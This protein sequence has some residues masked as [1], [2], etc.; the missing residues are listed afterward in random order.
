MATFLDVGILEH[1]SVIFIFLL[2]FAITYAVLTFSNPFGKEAKG[3]YAIIALAISFLVVRYKPAILMINFMTPWFLVAF[4]FI[5]FMLV[6]IGMFGGGQLNLIKLVS[7]PQVYIWIIIISVI[8][9]VFG[10]SHTMGQTLLER[11]PGN[12]TVSG[13]IEAGGSTQT[14][15]FSQ[16]VVNTLFHPKILGTLLI[17]MVGLFTIIFL[18]KMPK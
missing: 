7:D 16:N 15:S 6:I 2:I 5:F 8:I 14:S 11:G 10:L 3:L 13:Q 9:L 12:E 18:T 1:F 4:L 17:F